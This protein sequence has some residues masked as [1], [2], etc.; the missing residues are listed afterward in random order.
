ME[1]QMSN[2]TPLELT[3]EYVT[4]PVGVDVT[5][6]RFSWILESDQRGQMQSA[7]QIL[8]ASSK[9]KLKAKPLEFR[10]ILGFR[11]INLDLRLKRYG[12]LPTMFKTFY[13]RCW[14]KGHKLVEI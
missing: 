6:P 5:E 10:L 13:L 14:V 11:G 9:E 12:R 3:C 2:I 8:V 4:D 7:Y 1:A